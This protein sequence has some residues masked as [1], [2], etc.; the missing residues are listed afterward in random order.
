VQERCSQRSLQGVS[1]GSIAGEDDGEA[2]TTVV[3]MVYLQLTHWPRYTT[4]WKSGALE[5]F[6]WATMSQEEVKSRMQLARLNGL[7]GMHG[8]GKGK[9]VA[10]GDVKES[11]KGNGRR[12]SG[13]KES[14][15]IQWV[16]TNEQT[17]AFTA[18]NDPKGKKATGAGTESISTTPTSALGG[19]GLSMTTPLDLMSHTPLV[20]V[21]AGTHNFFATPSITP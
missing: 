16:N 7:I 3:S 15:N 13:G 11:A 8:E 4:E 14:N 12:S 20:N 1:V 6:V 5:T 10:R 17:K 2:G 9:E 18:A 21:S 19:L